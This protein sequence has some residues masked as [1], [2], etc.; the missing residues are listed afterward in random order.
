MN[1]KYYTFIFVISLLVG[2]THAQKQEVYI[3]AK[4][5]AP[6]IT[7]QHFEIPK[8]NQVNHKNMVNSVKQYEYISQCMYEVY[9]SPHY[10]T[11]IIL[12]PGEGLVSLVSGDRVRWKLSKQSSKKRIYIL[13]QPLKSGL[14]TNIEIITNKR[15]YHIEAKSFKKLYHAA[16]SWVYPENEFEKLTHQFEL[17]NKKKFNESVDIEHLCF[18]YKIKGKAWFKPINVFDDGKKTYIQFSR[19]LN[20]TPPP[21]FILKA[22]KEGE[23]ITN[24][25][26]VNN[27]YIVD[28]LFDKASLKD[29]SRVIYIL[30]R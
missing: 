18:N 26:F 27:Y 17:E 10:V 11:N 19:T 4:Q 25:K 8:L 30:R 6:K 13:V 16:I 20:K 15:I 7:N 12:Q 22:N 1:I 29:K 28:K 5:I 14:I 2:C 3:P 21:L 24:Y 23:L 9:C